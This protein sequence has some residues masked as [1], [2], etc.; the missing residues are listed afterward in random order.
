[1]TTEA[2][3]INYD[4][5]QGAFARLSQLRP[6]APIYTTSASGRVTAWIATR[7]YSR[8]KTQPL[9]AGAFAGPDGPRAL[10]LVSCGGNLIPGQR[11]YADNIYVFAVP[12]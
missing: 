8:P 11:S 2:G 3:H 1:M 4:G 12:A 7:A 6:G 9:D 10:V 5:R